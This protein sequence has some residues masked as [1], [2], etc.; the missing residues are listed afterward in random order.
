MK[1]VVRTEPYK[2]DL[3]GIEAEISKD[4]P[5][6]GL[7]M[8]LHI[9]GQVDK[10]SDNNFPRKPGRTKGTFELVAHKNYIVILEEDAKTVTV[11]NVV[12]ARQKWPL[13]E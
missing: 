8:W 10:L 4:N 7:A 12:H 9:D 1:T 13:S 11:L 6:A 5:T 3:E 2:D